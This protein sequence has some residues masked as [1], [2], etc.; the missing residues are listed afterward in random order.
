MISNRTLQAFTTD[1][2]GVPLDSMLPSEL[3]DNGTVQWAAV[4]TDEKGQ[5]S[6]AFPDVRWNIVTVPYGEIAIEVQG[7]ALG[8]LSVPEK[9]EEGNEHEAKWGTQLDVCVCIQHLVYVS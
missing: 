2:T 6:Y 1:E 8:V 5:L 4:S 9:T 7:W 3:G